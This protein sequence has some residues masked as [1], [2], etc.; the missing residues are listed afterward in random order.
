MLGI[1]NNKAGKDAIILAKYDE[2]SWNNPVAHFVNKDGLDI[3][4]KLSNN[5]HPLAMLD[6]MIEALAVL[7]KE[8]P[9]YIVLFQKELK[10]EYG[11]VDE[12]IYETPCF[13]SGET[14]FAQHDAVFA[15]LPGFI[16]NREV[17][18]INYDANLISLAAL[19]N[20]ALEQGFFL[21]E[22]HF[23]F[24][25]DKDPHYYLKKTKYKYFP[26][27]STQ[28]TAINFAIPY[29]KDPDRHLSPKQLNWLKHKKL[30]EL[31]HPKAYEL[32]IIQSWHFLDNQL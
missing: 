22:E 32:N 2:T 11:L 25:I 29:K 20:F 30:S 5:Y 3:I 26:L 9:D 16:G 8:L 6:K 17:V 28:K 24:K 31:S 10:I 7:N 15:T 4:E 14:T 19:N 21:I 23:K 18:K 12:T 13:W 27:T 1:Y